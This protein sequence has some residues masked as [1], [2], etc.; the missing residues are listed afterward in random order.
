MADGQL[1]LTPHVAALIFLG[2]VICGHNF[3]RVW[4]QQTPGWQKR[5]WLF[6]VPAAIG[7]LALG[8]LPLKL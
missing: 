6:G 7:L 5:A 4:K 3:R 2:V 8:F 1:Y